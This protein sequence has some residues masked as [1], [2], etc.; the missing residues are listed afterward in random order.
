MTYLCEAADASGTLQRV[1]IEAG[2][3]EDA[4][5]LLEAKGYGPARVIGPIED[6]REPVRPVSLPTQ[7]QAVVEELR[8]MRAIQQKEARRKAD[9][10]ASAAVL[11]LGLVAVVGLFV[12]P[13]VGLLFL[14]VFVL[15]CIW[16][17]G[18]GL[19]RMIA[20]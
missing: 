8:Q 14:A 4:L 16:R 19:V 18:S 13:P 12:M 17:V 2:N 20:R 3:P 9:G 15:V 1:R 11:V 10:Q 5:L 7:D 6:A